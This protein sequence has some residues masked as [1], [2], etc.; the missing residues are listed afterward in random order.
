MNSA[1][2][3]NRKWE[4][5]E[6][7]YL[8][9]RPW[10]TARRDHVR[11]P[12]GNEIPEYYILEYPDWVNIIAITK[13]GEFV[14]I[15]QYRHGI[16]ETSFELCAGV[17]DDGEEPLTAAKRELYEETGY[18]NGKWELWMTVS[19]NPSSMT[20]LSYSYIATDVE[21]ISTQHLEPTEDISVHLMSKEDVKELLLSGSIRQSLMAAPL[22]KLFALSEN[23][24]N[25]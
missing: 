8:I 15:R 21:K 24:T 2:N 19:P 9:R 5:L 6:S 11:L 22:W 17:C 16:G 23:E 4:V 12:N 20:N 1:N 13:E 7:E 25:R 3:E 14:M 18:G 10:L